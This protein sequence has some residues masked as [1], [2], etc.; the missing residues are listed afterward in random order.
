MIPVPELP[1]IDIETFHQSL[2]GGEKLFL[3]KA[4]IDHEVFEFCEKPATAAD[5][6]S[7]R[8]THDGLTEKFFNALAAAGLLTKT[9]STFQN[10][11]LSSAC[12]IEGKPFYQGNLIGLMLKTRLERWSNLGKCLKEGPLQPKNDRRQVFDARFIKAMAEGA[13][14]GGLHRT[15]A[16]VTALP[17]FQTASKLVDIG[18]GHGLYAI[19]FAQANPNLQSVVFDLPQVVDVTSDYI[20]SYAIQDRVTA[21][22]GDY[23]TD[24]WGQ[25]VDIVFASDCLYRPP[26]VLVPV[27]NRIKDSLNPG[28]LFISKHWMMDDERTSPDTTV[29]F[30]LMVSLMGNFSGHIYTRTEW[31]QEIES[32]GFAVEGVDISSPS[33]PSMLFV[34]RKS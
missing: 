13:M 6:S 17:E 14:R 23:T 3:I 28:G 4:A 19:A 31:R 12:F 25:G 24:D 8:G 33:K 20:Q 15:V 5:F 9:D 7:T 11:P 32:T 2:N 18:G 21:V 26:E 27:L 34:G 1:D 29:Y 10:S 22:A 30:D 16:T